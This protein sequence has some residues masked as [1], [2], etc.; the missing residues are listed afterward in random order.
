MPSKSNTIAKEI[1]RAFSPH[2]NKLLH[3]HLAR[4]AVIYEDLRIEVAAI[5]EEPISILDT[6]DKNYRRNYFLRRFIGTIIEFAEEFRFLNGLDDFALVKN[7]F[8]KIAL[9]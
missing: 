3:D 6:T 8:D 5:G 1:K 7:R 9:H 2:T 4:L